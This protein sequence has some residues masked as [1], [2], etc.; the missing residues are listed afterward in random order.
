MTP[1]S[2]ETAQFT[3][4]S[5]MRAMKRRSLAILV[6]VVTACT[7]LAFSLA[8]ASAFA[9]GA[10]VYWFDYNIDATTHMKTLNQDITI[11]GGT[12]TGGIDF[13]DGQLVGDI[14]L[15]AS[16]FTFGVGPVGLLTVTAKIIATKH[17]NGI[18]D[19]G[20]L[21]VVATS[22]FNVQLVSAYA[23]GTTFPNLVGNKCITATPAS[24]TM[25]GSASIGGTST[26]SGE[27]TMPPF[28]DCGKKTPILNLLLAGPGNT[29][30]ATA[31]PAP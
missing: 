1:P 23:T 19:F 14:K 21:T 4:G 9:P 24:V 2:L 22:T 30:T 25:S 12:F 20:S 6:L 29:F 27:F 15:P 11:K 18:V 13:G 5:A 31:S 17:V 26:F 3:W 28:K 7:P 10:N 16:T 8:P